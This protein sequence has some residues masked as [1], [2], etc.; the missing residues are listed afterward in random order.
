MKL[1]KSQ[2]NMVKINKVLIMIDEVNLYSDI[3]MSLEPAKD[4]KL[5][6]II[7]EPDGE[8]IIKNSRNI[9]YLKGIIEGY[10]TGYLSNEL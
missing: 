1:T 5:K 2:K 7:L 6:L 9:K 4:R 8:P 3:T 10:M